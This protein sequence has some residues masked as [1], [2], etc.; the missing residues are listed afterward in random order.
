MS[1]KENVIGIIYPFPQN[2]LER[3]LKNKNNVFIKNST[4]DKKPTYL[5]KGSKILFYI[6]SPHKKIFAVGIIKEI[7]ILGYE[8]LIKKHKGKLMQNKDELRSYCGLG[9]INGLRKKAVYVVD[10]LKKIENGLTLPFPITM[11]GR[12][13][14]SKEYKEIIKQND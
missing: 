2:I 3:S 5:E 9:F 12:Y 11:T 14:N 10:S 13:I 1:K 4:T 7:V 8:E 6:G